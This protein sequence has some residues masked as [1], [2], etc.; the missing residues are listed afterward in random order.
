MKQR[1]QPD[2]SVQKPEFPEVIHKNHGIEI[3]H[4]PMERHGLLSV[5]LLLGGGADSDHLAGC[6]AFTDELLALQLSRRWRELPFGGE[7]NVHTGW[8][9]S[10]LAL[11]GLAN[12]AENMTAIIEAFIS[13]SGIDS[14]SVERHK[15][16][17]TQELLQASESRTVLS[18][19]L[20]TQV[21]HQG[22][23]REFG[24][25]GNL[26]QLSRLDTAAV[27][28]SIHRRLN[29]PRALLI[30]V[31]DCQ[32]EV[33]AQPFS[34]RQV[35]HWQPDQHSLQERQGSFG[36][37]TD[38][39][40]SELR[41]SIPLVQNSTALELANIA[42]GGHFNSRL[43]QR[44]RSQ[45]GITYGCGSSILQSGCSPFLNISTSV[46]GDAT[47]KALEDVLSCVREWGNC[48]STEELNICKRLYTTAMLQT[49]ESPAQVANWF[50][51]WIR[52]HNSAAAF[53]QLPTSIESTQLS[54]ILGALRSL[55]TQDYLVTMVT[56]ELPA[57]VVPTQLL[58]LSP[59]E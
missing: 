55:T 25:D 4:L 49:L 22:T 2:L 30:V 10:T 29:R 1:P 57:N 18:N 58:K 28:G 41:I 21:R 54:D 3:L 27:S 7:L 52:N 9:S 35:S 42:L 6:C 8:G 37:L 5:R 50:E 51:D 34:R 19:W 53:S 33:L 56:E 17:S 38:G 20:A 46:Q 15:H 40:Q 11:D 59:K 31:G 16:S 32:A 47:E 13:T 12:E 39:P 26:Y 43:N 23:Q 14:V 48:W 45:N 24:V 44:L 36:Y